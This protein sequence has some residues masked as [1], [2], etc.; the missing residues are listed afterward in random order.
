MQVLG[1]ELSH[2][3]L[4]PEEGLSCKHQQPMLPTAGEENECL[5]PAEGSGPHST[6]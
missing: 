6:G 2:L 1:R 5:G 3:R 4:I